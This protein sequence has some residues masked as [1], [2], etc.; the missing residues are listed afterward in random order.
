MKEIIIKTENAEKIMNAINDVQGKAKAR[1]IDSFEDIERILEDI[2]QRLGDIPKKA[3]E[4]TLVYYD[5]R[6]HFPSAYRYLPDS[7]HL[8][9]VYRKGTWRLLR[10]G[11]GRC[12]NTLKQYPYELHLSDEAKE[13]ILRRYE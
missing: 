5:F 3:L 9:L 6:Q 13:A 12:P 10:V 1:T 4:G 7:T 2:H 11:R 8:D